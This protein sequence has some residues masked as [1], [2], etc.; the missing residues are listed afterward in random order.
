M[1][2]HAY[3]YPLFLVEILAAASFGCGYSLNSDQ[4]LKKVTPPTQ[5]PLV[6]VTNS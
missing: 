4:F 1:L 2:L 5:P 6:E 3:P